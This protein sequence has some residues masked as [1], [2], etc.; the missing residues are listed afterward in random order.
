[1]YTPLEIPPTQITPR[2]VNNHSGIPSL[3]IETTSPLSKPREFKAKPM[4]FAFSPYS[5]HE[6]DCQIP[7]SF[8]RIAV[9]FFLVLTAFQKIFGTVSNATFS[10]SSISFLLEYRHLAAPNKTP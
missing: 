9:L 1:M 3:A 4:Y 8:S 2:S 5:F 10:F 7:R 6:I